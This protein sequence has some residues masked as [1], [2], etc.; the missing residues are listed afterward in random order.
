MKKK[1][2]RNWCIHLSSLTILYESAVWDWCIHIS[3]L[4]LAMQWK[5]NHISKQNMYN[6]YDHHEE[7]REQ[8]T[9]QFWSITQFYFILH[10]YQKVQDNSK[11]RE[12]NESCDECKLNFFSLFIVLLQCMPYNVDCSAI[13]FELDAK[14][15]KIK[16]EKHI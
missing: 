3:A 4:L 10:E 13:S 12:Q 15:M 14:W 2:E 7:T 11:A 16:N 9:K 6:V 1:N 5:K 8:K